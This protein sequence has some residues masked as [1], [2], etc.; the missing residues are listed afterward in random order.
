MRRL[1]L[2]LVCLS[3][4]AISTYA[5]VTTASIKGIVNTFDEQ[6]VETKIAS[7]D[8][9]LTNTSDGTHLVTKSDASGTLY[10]DG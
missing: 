3:L 6:K 7:A 4:C 2:T 8:I 9:E 5:Q 1:Q 10:I